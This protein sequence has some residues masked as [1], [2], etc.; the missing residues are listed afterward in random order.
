MS[1]A[2]KPL[3]H[4]RTNITS[5]WAHVGNTEVTL[6]GCDSTDTG[7]LAGRVSLVISTGTASVSIRPTLI[8]LAAMRDMLTAA[9][10]AEGAAADE[11]D[12]MLQALDDALEFIEDHEDVSD[13][14]DGSPRPNRAMQLAGPIRDVIAKARSAA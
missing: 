12:N 2:A 8:E 6:M 13:G 10:R 9:L 14:P 7:N 1:Q 4:E 3:F 11:S 5:P